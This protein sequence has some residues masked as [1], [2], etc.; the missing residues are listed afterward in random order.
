VEDLVIVVGALL[1]VLEQEI[2]GTTHEPKG[3]QLSCREIRVLFVCGIEIV[4][5][6]G[7]AL[8]IALGYSFHFAI[9]V[10]KLVIRLDCYC[11]VVK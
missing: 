1:V 6:S 10:L 4:N 8:L 11:D 3:V 7:S 5:H 2:I 9:L